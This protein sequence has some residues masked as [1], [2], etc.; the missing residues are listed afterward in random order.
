MNYDR[1]WTLGNKLRVSEGRGLGGWASLVV[2]IKEGTYCME[3]WVLI[4]KQ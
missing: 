2:D 1:L 3:H 4:R